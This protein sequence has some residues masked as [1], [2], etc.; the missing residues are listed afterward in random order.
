[1]VILRI[2]GKLMVSSAQVFLE[3]KTVRTFLKDEFDKPVNPMI[4]TQIHV[5]I[6][7][8]IPSLT[9]QP[10]GKLRSMTTHRVDEP[11]LSTV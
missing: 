2:N 7:R 5:S 8:N 3:N 11:L 1:M 4:F 10:K 9:E 6:L